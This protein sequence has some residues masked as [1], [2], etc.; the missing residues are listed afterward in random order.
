MARKLNEVQKNME[1]TLKAR[2]LRYTPQRLQIA[3]RVLNKH[4]H[5]TADDIVAWSSKLK[6]RLSRATVYNTL[7]EFVA[8]GL[9]KSF[10]STSLDKL[11]FDSNTSSHF[12]FL[13]T[14][15]NEIFDVDSQVLVI[16]PKALTGYHIEETEVLFRGRKL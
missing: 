12:H 14:L 9:L 7:N 2:G 8:V 6:F 16:K 13:D 11:I 3:L 4:N 5:F 15:T 10:Y 1:E